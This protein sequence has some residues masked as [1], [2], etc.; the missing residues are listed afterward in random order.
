MASKLRSASSLALKIAVAVGLIVYL[1]RS[2]HLDFK[3]VWDMMT[4]PNVLIAL[5]LAGLS[6]IFSAWRWI[7]S[8][9]ARGFYIPFGYGIGLYL[10]G[11]FFSYALP[12]SVSGDLVR[13]YYLVQDYPARKMDSVLSVLID[14]VLGLYSFFILT[15]AA[16]LW[17]WDFVMAHEKIRWIAALT[18]FIFLG[19]TLF[20]LLGFSGRIYRATRLEFI[21]NKIGPLHK[22]MDGFQRFGQDRKIIAVSVLVSLIAQVF[23]MTF[24]YGIGVLM[25]EPD[26]SWNA[27]MFAVPMG[28]VVT[29]IP[30]APAGVGVGQVAFLY[31]FQTYMNKPSQYGA[32]AITAFQLAVAVWALSGV[33]FYLRRRKPHELEGI[34]SKMETA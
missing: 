18:F 8:L 15:L 17:D 20:F 23:T 25:H 19:M 33:F 4:V 1:V 6:V 13:G 5:T 3:V 34:E 26:V 2:G 31:L 10:I 16:V 28:F 30:I 24:F 21:V 32:V 7:I 27:I 9:K 14:R 22:V 29:A 12:G 11:M